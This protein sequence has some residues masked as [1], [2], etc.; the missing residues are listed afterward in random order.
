MDHGNQ[1]DDNRVH[2]PL[3]RILIVLRR[4]G[5]SV[6]Y[7]AGGN[8]RLFSKWAMNHVTTVCVTPLR[9]PNI[10]LRS[11]ASSGNASTTT[12]PPS[13][14]ARTSHESSVRSP[15]TCPRIVFG[16]LAVKRNASGTEEI[17]FPS[18]FSV[19]FNAAW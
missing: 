7:L 18:S 6:V 11:T 14:F 15:R 10:S 13:P 9:A 5:M 19:A 3:G 17:I 8:P 4:Q 2:R 12:T 1:E 16:N